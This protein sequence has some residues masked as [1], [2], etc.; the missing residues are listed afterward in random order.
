[1]KYQT[2]RALS[3]S[4]NPRQS[5]QGIFTIQLLSPSSFVGSSLCCRGRRKK[6]AWVCASEPFEGLPDLNSGFDEHHF[7]AGFCW[8]KEP[9]P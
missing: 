8:V 2:L 1:M 5:H 4:G 3:S 9:F 7:P 6:P